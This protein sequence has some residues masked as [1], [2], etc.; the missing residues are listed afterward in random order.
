MAEEKIFTIPMRAEKK[1]RVKRSAHAVRI[2]RAYLEKHVKAG[3]I[4]LG[5]RLNNAVWQRGAKKPPRALRVKVVKDGETA[6]AELVGF[7]YEEF[8]TKPKTEKKGMKERLMERLGPKAQ[9]KQELEEKI[10]GKT[11]EEKKAEGKKE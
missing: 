1:T 6:K 9:Q 11:P 7:D 2:I 4:K 3:E 10:E 5:R 8:R